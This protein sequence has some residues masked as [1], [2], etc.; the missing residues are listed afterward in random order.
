MRKTFIVTATSCA[1]WLATGGIANAIQIDYDF[2]SAAF[3]SGYPVDTLAT[4]VNWTLNGVNLTV[5]AVEVINDNSGN[6][7][8]L[9]STSALVYIDTGTNNQGLGAKSYTSDS[10]NLLDG[11]SSY[12]TLGNGSREYIHDDGL[13]FVFD[14]VVSLDFIN[15]GDFY[16]STNDDFNVS[17]FD[18]SSYVTPIVD[19]DD[20]DADTAFVSTLDNDKFSFANI[21]GTEFIIWA[22]GSS[23]EFLIDQIKVST[24]ATVPAPATLPL[25]TLGLAGLAAF[26]RRRS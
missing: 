5:S 22:D 13:R 9:D 12:N 23:D 26:S 10:D 25:L 4:S 7:I 16:N 19:H 1:I 6:I 17:F 24:V 20:D 15:L 21:S 2:E 14:T 18:G 8:R 3:Q 11:S